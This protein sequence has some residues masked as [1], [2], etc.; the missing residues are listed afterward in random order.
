MNLQQLNQSGRSVWSFLVTAF[1]SLFVTGFMWFCLEQ[2]NSVVN[3]ARK[4]E[5]YWFRIQK[6]SDKPEHPIAVR[7][8][9]SLGLLNDHRIVF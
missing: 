9:I 4:T 8:A 5:E 1:V 6:R 3:W 7:V 2:Y